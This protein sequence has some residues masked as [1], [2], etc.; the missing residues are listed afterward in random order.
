MRRVDRAAVDNCASTGAF[1]ACVRAVASRL[2][3]R[4]LRAR[5]LRGRLHAGFEQGTAVCMGGGKC[6]CRPL[7]GHGKGVRWVSESGLGEGVT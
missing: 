3:Q 4:V 6:R 1:I 5:A 7:V 2:G